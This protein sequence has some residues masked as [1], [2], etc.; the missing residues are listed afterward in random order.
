LTRDRLHTF[1]ANVPLVTGG[2]WVR[3]GLGKDG[4]TV[5]ENAVALPLSLHI[6]V[7]RA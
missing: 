4:T 6:E 5:P 1:S 3:S 7:E 2:W